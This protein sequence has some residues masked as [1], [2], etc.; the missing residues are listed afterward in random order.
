[1]STIDFGRIQPGDLITS[2]FMNGLLGVIEDLRLRVD[3]L[4]A[5]GGG[6]GSSLAPKITGFNV[7]E[8][9]IRG[10]LEINGTGFLVPIT[11]NTVTIDGITVPQILPNSGATKLIVGVPI[12]IASTPRTVTV[13]VENVNGFDTSTIRVLPEQQTPTGQVVITDQT[14]NL[15][16]IDVGNTY[17]FTYSVKS[18][19]TIGE[20]YDFEVQYS[21]VVGAAAADWQTGTTFI[22]PTSAPIGS[23]ATAQVSFSVK[24]PASATSADMALRVKSRNN[25]SGLSRASAPFNLKV[26]ATSAVNDPRTPI[27]LPTPGFFAKY[28]KVTIDGV[29]GFEIPYAGKA[30]VR[31]TPEP[32]IAGDYAYTAV[33][34]SPDGL[35]TVGTLTPA[36]STEGALG[37]EE[38]LFDVSLSAANAGANEKRFLVFTA[39]RTNSD[40]VGQF[41]SFRRIPIRGFTP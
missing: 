15:G 32:T 14:P 27:T 30:T 4:E 5:H 17:T 19:T 18:E 20:T 12:G 37:S 25:D 34:E 24:V 22:S 1:M 21:N 6:G 35:W 38:V 2:E 26:G 23:F 28:R 3:E 8:I 36:S 31:V 7:T 33:V 40:P 41:T 16:Q 39:K 10:Q 13:K 11:Q 29:E 9:P